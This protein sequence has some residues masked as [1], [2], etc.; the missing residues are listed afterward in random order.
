MQ[1]LAIG[2]SVKVKEKYNSED[3]C[4]RIRKLAGNFVTIRDIT[5]NGQ[6]YWIKETEGL[7]CDDLWDID[8]FIIIE[9]K[10]KL[11]KEY[12]NC[13]CEFKR[14]I[15]EDGT[16]LLSGDY[17]HDKINE[18]I[19]GYLQALKDNNIEYELSTKEISCLN[20]Y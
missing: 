8:D 3:Y 2:D 18:R 1:R 19:E 11:I 10:M 16:E 12:T 9:D 15:K 4:D 13:D 6:W 20:E 14:L 7:K 5:E 17:Y